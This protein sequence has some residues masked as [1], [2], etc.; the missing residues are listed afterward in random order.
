L[1][2]ALNKIL[3]CKRGEARKRRSVLGIIAVIWMVRVHISD[4]SAGK[5]TRGKE[6]VWETPYG[7]KRKRGW[8]DL[9]TPFPR[10]G[11]EKQ[12]L[13]ST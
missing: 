3:F 11:A 6:M 9:L 7:E 1:L 5:N 2:Q 13:E 8:V 4:T 12:G 10:P